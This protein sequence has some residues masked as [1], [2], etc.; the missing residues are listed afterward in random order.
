MNLQYKAIELNQKQ[1]IIWTSGIINN[2]VFVHI[3]GANEEN[4][5]DYISVVLDEWGVITMNGPFTLVEGGIA[6]MQEH[7]D[8]LYMM[9]ESSMPGTQIFY[10]SHIG[11]TKF[12]KRRPVLPHW[13]IKP[14]DNQNRTS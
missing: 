13:W 2:R 7:R 10:E 9:A 14:N 8:E 3:N 5:N 1:Y 11:K 4:I 6:Y 12:V